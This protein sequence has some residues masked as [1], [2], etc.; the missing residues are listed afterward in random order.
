[1]RLSTMNDVIATKVGAAHAKHQRHHV[2]LA[3]STVRFMHQAYAAT[4]AAC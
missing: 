1:M 2:T 3:A 4:L